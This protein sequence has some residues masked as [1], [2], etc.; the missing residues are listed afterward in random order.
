VLRCPRCIGSIITPAR[1]AASRANIAGVTRPRQ[2]D[3]ARIRAMSADGMSISAIARV[4]GCS[5]STVS[6]ARKR[7]GE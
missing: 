7:K 6:N 1:I 4:L 2:Y 5:V 3:A